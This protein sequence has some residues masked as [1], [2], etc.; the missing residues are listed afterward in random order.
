MMAWQDD[1]NFS[2]I[3]FEKNK[4]EMTAQVRKQELTLGYGQSI[5]WTKVNEM[6][7]NSLDWDKVLQLITESIPLKNIEK[8]KNTKNS[9]KLSEYKRLVEFLQ[10]K[11]SYSNKNKIKYLNFWQTSTSTSTSTSRPTS[12]TTPQNNQEG[13]PNWIKW[14]GG[15]ILFIILIRACN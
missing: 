10:S 6:I 1:M 12:T 11:L 4:A 15:I 5:N 9:D 7:N 14:V 8:I 13:I 2:N 3:A